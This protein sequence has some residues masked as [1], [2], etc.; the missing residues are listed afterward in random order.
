MAIRNRFE[1]N[2]PEIAAQNR[3]A[4]KRDLERYE[5][6]KKHNAGDVTEGRV[7]SHDE[8]LDVIKDVEGVE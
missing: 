4:Q 2:Y 1:Q 3:A 7:A 5:Q 6:W 8:A